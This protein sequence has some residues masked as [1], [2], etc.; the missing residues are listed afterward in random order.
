MDYTTIVSLLT[1]NVII[2]SILVIVLIVVAITIL[3]NLNRLTKHLEKAAEKV[4]STTDWLKPSK[5][6][7]GI[8]SLFR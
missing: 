8:K 3:V 2:L 6:F 1:V 5:V 4:A 7:E